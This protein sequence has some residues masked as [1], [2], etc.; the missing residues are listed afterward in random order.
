MKYAKHALLGFDAYVD[1]IYRPV[2]ERTGNGPVPYAAMAEYGQQII[3][4]AGKS[5]DMDLIRG[6]VHM[7]GN[8][9]LM[10]DGMA[11][12]GVPVHLIC[13]SG[14]PETDPAFRELAA[15]VRLDAI[16]SPCRSIALE[17]DDGKIMMGDPQNGAC[18][19]LDELLSQLGASAVDEAVRDANLIAMVNWSSCP[20]LP[21]IARYLVSLSR[22]L[23]LPDGEQRLFFFDLSD[24]SSVEGNRFS[25]ILDCIREIGTDSPTVLG[26]NRNEFERVLA[27]MGIETDGSGE[28]A[29]AVGSAGKKLRQMLRLHALTVHTAKEAFALSA[30]GMWKADGAYTA[31]PAFTTG[32]GDHYNAGFCWALLEGLSLKDCVRA[33][34]FAAAFYVRKGRSAERKDLDALQAWGTAE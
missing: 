25:Q 32:A 1:E 27:G 16:G 24:P 17:F 10:A 2:R 9:P 12:L 23:P 26:L 13:G 19:C 31:H 14:L 30:D 20:E 5:I 11:A 3:R 4:A 18:V 34:Y 7:G 15:R 8:A 21:G 33:A 28:L 6:R 22:R 29:S